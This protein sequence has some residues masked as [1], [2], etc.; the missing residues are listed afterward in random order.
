MCVVLQ[1]RLFWIISF[2]L[3]VICSSLQES[4]AQGCNGAN[5]TGIFTGS[6]ANRDNGTLCANSPVQPGLMEID[7]SNIDESGTIQFE[8]NWDDGSA[9]QRVNAF[10][11]SANRYFAQVTHMFPANGAQ[12]RCEYRPDVRLVFNG[13]VCAATLGVPPRFVRWNTDDQQTGNL[14]LLETITNVNEYL[15]CAGVE[16]NV[17]FTDRSDLN[18]VPPDLVLGPNDRRRWRQ[19]VYG[20]AN[21]ITGS[22]RIGGSTTPFPSNGAVSISTEPI[23]TSG[24]PTTT[25]EVITVPATAQVGEVFEITMNYWNTCNAFPARPP[26][27]ETARIRIVAQPP[28]PTGNDLT[29]CNG[30]TPGAFSIAG[31]PPGNIVNWYRNVPGSPDAPGTLITS[32]TAT[33]LAVNS[34][35]VP[36]YTN[37]TT[38]GVYSVW[39]SYVPNVANALNCES[40]KIQ[41]RRTIRN[42]LA[43]ANPTTAPP[44][45]VC[46]NSSFNIV[47]PNPATETFGGNTQYNFAGDVGVS[48]GATTANSAT[49]NVAVAFA[50]GELFVDRTISVTRRYSTNPNCG[51]TRTFTVRVYNETVAGALTNFPDVCEGTSV[52]PITLS[53]HVGTITGWEVEINGGGWNPYAGPAS[54]NS[55]TPGILSD[56]VYRF[57]AI[58]DNG[59]CN[60]LNSPIETVTV[61]DNPAPP[62]AG[63]NQAFCGSLVSAPQDATLSG[64]VGT[65]SYVSSVPAGRPSPTF[66]ANDENT[67][68]TIGSTAQAGA[69]TMRWSVVVGSCTFEDD[70]V[71]DFGANP[72]PVPPMTVNLCGESGN[73]TAPVPAI[74]SGVWT[75]I[76][77]PS[78]CVTGNCPELTLADPTS[79]TSAISLNAPITYG[80]YT[81]EWRV[82]SGI[83]APAFN[84]ATVTFFQDPTATAS[85]INGICLDPTS[86][87]IPLTGTIGGGAT[88]GT[89]VNVDGNGTIGSINVAGNTV[90]AVYTAN[91]TDYN[92][93]SPIR[94]RL[95]GLP[96]GTSTCAPAIQEII[97]NVDREPIADAGPAAVSVCENFY[98]L[99]AQDPPPF[100]ATGMWT[101]PG[102]ITFDDPTDPST[103][104]RNLPAPGSPSVTLRWTLT[105]AGGNSCTAFD[106]VTITRIVAPAATDITPVICE[107]APAGGP[108][109]TQVL[110]TD[111]ENSVTTVPA[112]NRTI[113]WYEDGAPPLGT[114]IADP[115]VARV[116]VPDGKI[117]VARIFDTAT[118]CRSDAVVSINIRP[119]PTVQDAIVALC[120]DAPGTNTASNIDL[121]GDTRFR[122][123]VT[124]AGNIV[125][126][127]SS[128]ADAQANVSP[129]VAAIPTVTGSLDVF[130]RVTYGTAPACP[131]IAR[132]RLQ[133]NLLPNDVPI[134]G[135]PT[136]CMGTPGQPLNTLPVQTYQVTSVP[137]AKYYWTIPTGPGQFS[138]FAGGGEDDFYVLLQ[139]PYTAAPPVETIRVRIELNG[140]SSAELTLPIT[141][142]QQPTAPVITGEPVVCENEDGIQYSVTAPNP[143]SDYSWEIRRQSDNTIG[144]AFITSGQALPSIFVEFSDEDVYLTVTEISSVCASPEA[145]F[146]VT[147]NLRPIMA[148]ND[149][150]VCSDS[151]TNIVFL[152]A[153][154]SP[155]AIDKF[156]ISNAIYTPGLGFK[157]PLGP[158]TFPQ[159]NLPANF[160][161]NHVFENLTPS[162]L[163]VNYTVTPVSVGAAARECTGTA[164]I[165]TVTVKPEPQLSPNLNKAI[166]SG[167]E[168]EI[169]LMSANNTFPSDRFIIN[170]ITVPAGVTALSPIPAADGTT[171][172][173]DNILYN[174]IWENT[175]GVNQVVRYEIL[176]Y[177]TSLGCT[178]NPATT[179]DVTIYPRTDVNPVVVPPLCNGDL[180]NV[181]FSSPN[182]ADA[183]YLWIV[184]AYDPHITLG[185]PAAGSGNIANMIINNTSLTLDGTVTF[186]V[187]GKNPPAEEGI[188]ECLN[189]VQ[190]FVVTVR[191]SPVANA[192]VLSACSDVAG[193]NTYTADLKTLEPS[194]TPDAGDPNTAITW[195]EDAGLTTQIPDDG[196]LDAYIVTDN[197]PVYVVVEYLPTSCRRVVTVRYNVNPAVSLA[198][199]LSDFNGFNLNCN[200]DNSGQIRVDVLTGSP[201]YSYRIDGGPFINAGTQTYVFNSLAAGPHVVEVQ[202]ARGCTAVENITL[203][204]P[205][206]LAA[207]LAIDQPIS[208]FL[209][210]DGVISTVA[211]GGSGSYSSY[212]L[213][214]TNTVDPNNDGIFPNLSAGSYNVRV[215][216]SNG[217][218]VDSAPVSLVNPLQVELSATVVMNA[219]GYALSCKDATDA[220]IDVV[221]A[222]GNI[223]TTY[224]YTLVRS[225][226]PVNP[227]RVITAGSANESFQ[228]LPFGSY[229][230]T[231]TDRNNCPS[232]PVSVIIINPPP[233]I[234]GLIGINQSICVGEDPGTINELVPPFGGIGGY[235]FQWQQSLTGSMN[236]ADWISIPG[237]ISNE[238]DPSSITQT[239][240]YRRLVTSGS[241]GT[242]GKDNM[243]EVTVNP[244]PVVSFSAPSNVCQGESFTLSLSMSL[245]TAPIEYDYSAG[246]TTFSNLI[247][248]ENTM[249]PISNFQQNTTYTLLRVRD[250]NGCESTNVPQAV[251]VNL[252]NI[253]PD[254]EVLAPTAQCPGGTF[255]F[256]WTVE[257]GIKYTWIWTDGSQTVVNDPLSPGP[258]DR[259]PGVQTITHVFAAGSTESS[260]VYPV[261]LQ[262]ENA[263][264]EPKF[265]TRT[266][267]VYPNVFLNILPGELILCSGESTTFRD[268]SAGVDIGTWYYREKGTTQRLD[269]R[270]GPVA[271]VTYTFT[272]NTTTNP[273]YYEVIYE[274]S[275]SE[276]CTAE[277]M[278]EVKVYRGVTALMAT[279]PDP[280]APFT[281]GIS[282]VNFTNNS[283]PLDATD[284]EYTWDFGDVRAT[285]ANGSGTANYTVDYISAGIKNV[286]LRVVNIA[287]RDTDNKTCQSIDN[288]QLN[289]QLPMV[290]AAFKATPL[291]ACF[292]AD[293]TIE[294][295]SP[296]ADTFMWEL[297]DQTGLVTTSTLRNPVFRI[298]KPGVY[299]IYLTA[300]Y[301]ATGQSAQAEQKGIQI[302]DKPS[303]IFELRP[304]PLYVPDTEMQT[305]NKSARATQYEWIFDDGATSNE[306]EPRHTYKLE[307]KYIV[308]LVAGF[309]NG[310]KD[311]DGDGILDGN[312][313]CYDT[314]QQELVA[315][316]GGF[317]KLPNAFTP[318]TTGPSGGS[319]GNGTFND[320]F[321]PIM[322]GV[323]EF[324][325][326]IFDRWG[327]M[328]FESRDKN[329]GWDGYDKNGRALP[330]G[331]Y[332]YKL[333]LRLSDGQRTTKIG[334]VTLIK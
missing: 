265:A 85:D 103:T 111:Y 318:S 232:L 126:W 149:Q 329:I 61:T 280:P 258:E 12:V 78:G 77:G 305:F 71:I 268:Q 53:G 180:L 4:F 243:V 167:T 154:S 22:V 285:P 183:G 6:I 235:Q 146:P 240:Y 155:V 2:I 176:P 162:P 218:T 214:Q 132:L 57:R 47:L 267:T 185:S 331:V 31:V 122:D 256:Q 158:E 147:I 177:S 159:S 160:I 45:Q 34:T 288:K 252:I 299:D 247:G 319:A 26:V 7:I 150:L 219:G 333:V 87:A 210:T 90:T 300:S 316:D 238:F 229:T 48:V 270:S 115:T 46:N 286:T 191:K 74:G 228:N 169:T 206:T 128:V 21:T 89:W 326:Q 309:D 323:E 163:A 189:P 328:L 151:P 153:P 33:T 266:V 49:F 314:A 271:S 75:I 50:P 222:G 166:C 70:V 230:I 200:A 291:A 130:A 168:T 313:I 224:T 1:K 44:A 187:R 104:A 140:C 273:M 135:D 25:T 332:V 76:S 248:T 97:I 161:E 217:C 201:V 276:G 5:G 84:T 244:L 63:T 216:D 324:Q 320:V 212:L 131:I 304:N 325:M 55:I 80:A 254:F 91:A 179:V 294:N 98:Q 156:T 93:G 249:I 209:G 255:T 41:L 157:N 202:D 82:T 113:S 239:T 101:G 72:A 10:K 83:C 127:H 220:Q 221:A 129:I 263:L 287:A 173:L 196:S 283:T 322:R 52:G 307:G 251:D 172:Y 14:S 242:L 137:G 171:L 59:P 51:A 311:V 290:G 16:T 272:N 198:I 143:S 56:G 152:D 301:L 35:N 197:I 257:P 208:C 138:V 275:N 60:S 175:T 330:A 136:V 120:E 102:G 274:A 145:Q 262:A 116:N 297:Y 142:S 211:S 88:S 226:D 231:A 236:D 170:N 205:P 298:L 246:T 30:T 8:I 69:Y 110:L 296:G 317:M 192:Q 295:L 27:Q 188:D 227:Y 264:C 13:T 18:C 92:A 29:V 133:V 54:G 141:R 184:T 282:T 68:F 19:F 148:D 225:G 178:G 38:P 134:N 204:E 334:D 260:T 259:A 86:T 269:E 245:G 310:N 207:T 315:L 79:P 108:L 278:E 284:F 124:T 306:F 118:G 312:L 23:L 277:Y 81:L 234:A 65:W 237:A 165:I 292:P 36:G 95:E 289:I 105:S 114:L 20:T 223:P 279:N 199:T 9:P 123:A 40:P 303:S 215:E 181:A 293:I 174:N 112:A 117:Y 17:T 302:F 66:V 186:E 100:G 106:E 125:T 37:N 139:F 64:G 119:L 321:L 42:V 28:A 182:N 43:V 24:F 99:Q 194:I 32:G 67:T 250:L 73:L 58:V 62:T 109:T 11:I 193:G 261:R 281:G 164:Q 327:T 233:F 39:A 241:C 308:T 121:L 253:N 107:V 213:L 190:T 203:V 96:G 15:V 94:V 3:V 144:G 195:Y